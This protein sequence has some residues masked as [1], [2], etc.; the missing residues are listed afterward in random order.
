A[1]IPPQT[2][3]KKSNSFQPYLVNSISMSI[4]KLAPR[5]F[6]VKWG[7]GRSIMQL[8]WGRFR[9]RA[10]AWLQGVR[11]LAGMVAVA[12]LALLLAVQAAGARHERIAVAREEAA[13]DREMERLRRTNRALR[14]EI[15]ALDSDP[16]Y[17]EAL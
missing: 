10:G 9:A 7:I 11:N 15:R 16:V 8:D 17:V 14:D 12:A 3:V 5:G 6:P 13:M 1:P 2:I 4:T